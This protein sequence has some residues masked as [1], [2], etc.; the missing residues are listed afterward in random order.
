MVLILL[1]A[2]RTGQDIG[3]TFVPLPDIKSDL[4]AVARARGWD[5]PDDMANKIIYHAV[6]L[7]V[8]RIDRR[9]KGGPKVRFMGM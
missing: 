1:R 9:G 8:A 4:R 6:G 5:E 7:K 3:D 2:V